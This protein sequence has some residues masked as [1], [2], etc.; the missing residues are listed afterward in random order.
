VGFRF[1]KSVKIAS[2][3]RVNFGKRD[4][5]LSF[6]GGGAT[7]KTIMFLI[8]ALTSGLSAA[9]FDSYF[10]KDVCDQVIEKEV[11]TICYD[12]NYKAAKTVGYTLY[13]NK[14]KK[15]IKK[16]P[17]F[18][19]EP[20]LRASYRAE[21]S[22]YTHSGYDRGHLANDADF[23]YSPTALNQTYSLANIVPQ[24]PTV[25]RHMWTKAEKYERL[26]AI[27]LDTVEVLNIVTFS[28]N[29]KRIGRN[30]IAIPNGFWKK[31]SNQKAGF[32][33]CFYYNNDLNTRAKGDKL[34]DHVVDCSKLP[35]PI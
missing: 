27:K 24:A 3:V 7:V 10:K 19:P 8:F 31:I 12:Y 21:Y 29:P 14:V 11:Y 35:K 18:Y 5:S 26:M 15:S 20:S 34:K 6:G 13:G 17:K 23:D 25:N 9:S 30:S 32:E 22:D 28:K 1:R 33:R 4:S 16:R 2:G